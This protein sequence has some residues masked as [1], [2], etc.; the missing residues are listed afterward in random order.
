MKHKIRPNAFIGML[1]TVAISAVAHQIFSRAAGKSLLDQQRGPRSRSERMKRQLVWALLIGAAAGGPTLAHHSVT[2]AFDAEDHF[3][4][5]GRIVE[6]EWVNPHVYIHME[7]TGADGQPQR[8]ALET[9]P[10]QFFRN[11]G[12]SKSMLEGDGGSATIT[13]IRGHDKSQLIGF[14]SRITFADGRFIQVTDRF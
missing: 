10:T 12:V 2:G 7:V 5:E 11:A 13:G 9:A 3:E 6:V 14:I 4:I 1:A 8:W